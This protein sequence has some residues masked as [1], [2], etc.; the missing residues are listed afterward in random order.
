[1]PLKR[2]VAALAAAPRFHWGSA[3]TRAAAGSLEGRL[4]G[5][6]VAG[7]QCCWEGKVGDFS[8]RRFRRGHSS[9]SDNDATKWG[10]RR[11]PIQE[12]APCTVTGDHRR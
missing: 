3:S 6:S 10:V 12:L 4:L 2:L 9:H 1:M 7:R 5:V 11:A 8:Q